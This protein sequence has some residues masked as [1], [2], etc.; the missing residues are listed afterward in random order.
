MRENTILPL[1]KSETQVDYDYLDG[2]EIHLYR[3][4]EGVP[5]TLT[6]ADSKGN[7]SLALTMTKTNGSVRLAVDGLHQGITVILHDDTAARATLA[8]GQQEI[9]LL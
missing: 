3:P 7:P 6:M 8:P 2:L 4:V 9:T 1:G 5:A